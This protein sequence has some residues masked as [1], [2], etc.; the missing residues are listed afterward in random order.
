MALALLA[1]GCSRVVITDVKQ[2]K[3][4]FLVHHYGDRLIA[5]QCGEGRPEGVRP[6]ALPAWRGLV[7]RL[8]RQPGS[9]WGS[10]ALPAPWGKDRVRWHAASACSHGHRR[11]AGQ[12]DRQHTRIFRYANDY[13][14]SVA[15]IASG[16]IDV[17][18]LISRRYA[19]EDKYQGVRVGGR[20]RRR[21]DQVVIDC[22]KGI[23]NGR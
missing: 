22:P 17:K 1:S 20:P 9:D 15:L 5:F 4:D 21:R 7:R 12:G 13:E 18:P 14:R 16:Q 19:F 11:H 10:A 3:L 6:A 2:E 23:L 8:Q